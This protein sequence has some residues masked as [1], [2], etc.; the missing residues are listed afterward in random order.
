LAIE[1]Q[2]LEAKYKFVKDHEHLEI[3]KLRKQVGTLQKR[4]REKAGKNIS[5][6]TNAESESGAPPSPKVLKTTSDSS[7]TQTTKNKMPWT[8]KTRKTYLARALAPLGLV[9]SATN[10]EYVMEKK[11][12]NQHLLTDVLAALAKDV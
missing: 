2:Q 8:A 12:K 1:K 5:D 7:P 9:S 6:S 3:Y 4:S 11:T 10:P